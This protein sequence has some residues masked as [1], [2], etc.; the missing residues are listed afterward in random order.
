MWFDQLKDSLKLYI[1]SKILN[2]SKESIL[3]TKGNNIIN[4]IKNQCNLKELNK[5]ENISELYLKHKIPLSKMFNECYFWN[6][7]FYTNWFTLD[8]RSST[9]LMIES[10]LKYVPL[11]I[12]KIIELGVGTGA[13]LIT[14][15]EYYKNATYTGIDI[16]NHALNVAKI[17]CERHN[18]NINLI[19]NNWL[20]D[21]NDSYDLC[22]A[23]PPYIFP[24]EEINEYAMFDPQKALF[25]NN[26]IW[27]Y[28]EIEKKQHL[29]KYIALEC[30]SN[31][32]TVSYYKY[33]PCFTYEESINNFNHSFYK[34][35]IVIIDNTYLLN[36]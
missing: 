35:R 13:V 15:S 2:K 8:P 16:C 30:N 23:N 28:K 19:K 6:K 25:D 1:A 31:S 18:I 14:L 32:E 4:V 34:S 17:N 10:I 20:S 36:K 12:N 26:P 7:S 9:E 33:M 3:L 27:F 24:H 29:F 21:I 11:N 22:I 5:M